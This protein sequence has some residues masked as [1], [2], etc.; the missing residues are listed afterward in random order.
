M[1]TLSGWLLYP[2]D[3]YLI[4]KKRGAKKKLVYVMELVYVMAT[5]CDRLLYYTILGIWNNVNNAMLHVR[6]KIIPRLL[7][8]TG[9]LP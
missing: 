9:L 6:N 1:A 5:L 8:L 4:N 7:L 3:F 2:I